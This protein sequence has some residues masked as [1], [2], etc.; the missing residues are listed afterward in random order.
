MRSSPE[1]AH[2][3]QG[4][5]R[6]VAVRALRGGVA[7]VA[8]TLPALRSTGQRAIDRLEALWALIDL[9]AT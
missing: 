2:A 6:G 9:A 7:P 4:V 5:D 3:A 8:V 1:L